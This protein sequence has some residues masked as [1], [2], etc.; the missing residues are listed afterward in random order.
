MSWPL[1]MSPRAAK[2]PKSWHRR[3][4]I[5]HHPPQLLKISEINLDCDCNPRFP[6]EAP[7]PW[8]CGDC[9]FSTGN[10]RCGA[11]CT[12]GHC[13]ERIWI[14]QEQQSVP[15]FPW[16]QWGWILLAWAGGKKGTFGKDKAGGAQGGKKGTF[17][18]GKASGA[19]GKKKG[20]FGKDKAGGAQVSQLLSAAET[21]SHCK[22]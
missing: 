14:C 20:I 10:H 17:G 19:Q 4:I 15:Q 7:C 13:G 22:S 12:L 5:F 2:E 3:K 9:R 21:C 16:A 18:K 8:S 6:G 11:F 1:Q